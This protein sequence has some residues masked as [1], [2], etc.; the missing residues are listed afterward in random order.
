[1]GLAAYP[2]GLI[3]PYGGKYGH[4][5]KNAARGWHTPMSGLV[6]IPPEYSAY[7][8]ID[9]VLNAWTARH[10]IEVETDIFGK[11]VRSFW[12]CNRNGLRRGQ[13]WMRDPDARGNVTVIA[14]ELTT[15]SATNW[16]ARE[17]RRATPQ[18][19][20]TV[21]DELW[22][23]MLDWGGPGAIASNYGVYPLG[24]AH[25]PPRRGYEVGTE[26]FSFFQAQW[27]RPAPDW[28]YLLGLAL[29]GAILWLLLSRFGL[30]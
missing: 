9:P 3:L 7:R 11:E 8:H 30:L 10:G 28:A 22:T 27:G 18:T 20:E 13:L 19:L 5:N 4:T 29:F 21:L 15:K 25:P 23:H 26:R 2:C 12:I 17:E 6:G 14:A 1:M 16:G 24:L